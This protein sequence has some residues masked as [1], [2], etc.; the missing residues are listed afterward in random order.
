M[1]MDLGQDAVVS[2]K[3]II[4]IFDLDTSTVSKK[5]REYLQRAEKE[6]SAVTVSL[7]DLPRSF[8]VTAGSGGEQKIYISPLSVNAVASHGAKSG[9]E[10]N[11]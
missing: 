1:Y 6:G 2:D 4:G 3:D 8:T 5:T 11:Y 10:K 9:N 7:Y